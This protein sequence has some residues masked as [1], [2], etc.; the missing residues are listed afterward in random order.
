M[1]REMTF[2]HPKLISTTETAKVLLETSRASQLTVK[3]TKTANFGPSHGPFI[4][5]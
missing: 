4:A 5:F 2:Q 3:L 1:M